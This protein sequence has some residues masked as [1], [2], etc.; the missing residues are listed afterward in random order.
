M[1]TQL[2]VQN[3]ALIQDINLEL[4][5][6]LNI[7]T[8]ETGAGKSILLGALGLLSGKRAETSV[9]R[10]GA[11]KC[12]IEGEF[13]IGSYNLSNFFNEYDL[14]FEEQTLIRRE[15]AAS[16]K[17]RA[18]V[19][20]SPVN[21][22]VLKE[23]SDKIIDV[24]SQHA[25]LIVNKPEFS[26]Q[27][28]DGFSQQINQIKVYQ[29]DFKKWT[30]LKKSLEVLEEK[31]NQE[32]LNL[33]FNQFQLNELT[34]AQ[35]K[36]GEQEELEK[37]FEIL[38]NSEAIKE[39]SA[40][41]VNNVLYNKGSVL[42]LLKDSEN[43]LAKLAGFDDSYDESKNRLSSA[44]IEIK[45]IAEEVEQKNGD[46]SS[47]S[48]RVDQIDERLSLLFNLQKKF[49]V[50]SIEQLIEKR[51]ELE[52][53]VNLVTGGNEEIDK[54]KLAISKLETSLLKQAEKLTK[55]RE[56]AAEKVANLVVK[57]LVLM[58]I[59]QAQLAFNFEP[60]NLNKWGSDKIQIKFSAN[61]GKALG[62]LNK[63][64]SGGELSR[65]MLSLK[66]I[67]S[68]QTSL[69]T[70]VFDEIDT[71]VSGEVADQMGVI[72]KEMG[73]EIQVLT[74]TH[75]PQIAAKGNAH[76][77]VFKSHESELTTSNIKKL[78]KEERVLEIAQMLSGSKI[79]SAAKQNAKELIG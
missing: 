54:L 1:L 28:L 39:H 53:A 77:N 70:I 18:F 43:A 37:E 30:E 76:F 72:M 29:G 16:G 45:D 52:E 27:L 60:I 49:N 68:L 11:K 48:F 10:E 41:I 47:D 75:L 25:N 31:Q 69:P 40:Q 14:D 63:T 66:K 35:L 21:L 4:E 34:T 56:K 6:G 62:D 79:T 58:G 65:V 23:L 42:E 64:A 67:M 78:N 7:I 5:N 73:K 50:S 15:V 19:N 44:L 71:G 20:D 9:V 24:H 61:K 13:N 38:N 57:D 2:H 59:S 36:E 33:D 17:S 46:L 8:G 12:V 32:K 3:F 74:I 22:S 55:G 26:F 51:V